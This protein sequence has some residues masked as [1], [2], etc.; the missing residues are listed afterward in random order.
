MKRVFLLT[1]A[2][3]AVT[4]LACHAAAPAT[5]GRDDSGAAAT[6]TA[7]PAQREWNVRDHLRP[8]QIILQSHRGAGV[9]MPENTLE[10]FE[11]GWELRTIPE[12][13]IRTTRDGVIV[14]FHDADFKRVVKDPPAHLADKGVADVTWDE[15]SKL[16]VGAWAGDTF[17]GRRVSRIGDVFA[18]MAKHPERHL[19]LDI[20]QVDLAKLAGEVRE[21]N[22]GPQVIL[23][24]TKYEQ[25]REWKRLLPDSQTLLWMGGTEEKLAGRF[26]DLRKTNFADVTQLQIHVKPAAGDMLAVKRDATDPFVPSDAFL[27]NAGEELRSKGILFQTLPWG[28][29]TPEVYWK[30]LDLGVMSFATDHPDVT[31][32]AIRT[33]YE[34]G[35]STASK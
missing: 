2:L 3:S 22:V 9:L 25:I 26:A 32:E 35:T 8:E 21:H 5:G 14:A 10:A 29:A 15:L 12:A 31:N 27:R 24:S 20:K 17:V 19:Y 18:L 6:R 11:K 1:A 28:G 33:Y 34:E 4:S 23:A 13:D 7:A 16:D 30:L